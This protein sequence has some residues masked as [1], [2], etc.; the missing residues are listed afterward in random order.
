M[1]GFTNRVSGTTNNIFVVIQ[2]F[3]KGK[4]VFVA[5]PTGSGKSLCYW[6]LP[7]L[8]ARKY[9]ITMWRVYYV[10][11]FLSAQFHSRNVPD[12]ISAGAYNLKLISVLW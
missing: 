12:P 7:S 3:C 4:D 5:L 8:F 9:Y 10:I 1:N 11:T 6:I 2:S